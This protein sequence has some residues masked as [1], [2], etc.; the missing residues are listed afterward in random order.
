METRDANLEAMMSA[1]DFNPEQ[2]GTQFWYKQYLKQ[3]AESLF[4]NNYE[5]FCFSFAKRRSMA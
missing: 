5:L 4:L 1:P 2:L 3:R